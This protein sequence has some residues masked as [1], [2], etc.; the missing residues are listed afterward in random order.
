MY[1]N[2]RLEIVL[3]ISLLIMFFFSISSINE[4][5]SEKRLYN[6]LN[7]YL[8]SDINNVLLKEK[9][10]YNNKLYILYSGEDE[11]SEIIGYIEFEKNF[12]GWWCFNKTQSTREN[13]LKAPVQ[14]VL[15]NTAL[16]IC[17]KN[18]SDKPY[19]L[20]IETPDKTFEKNIRKNI[21]YLYI[22]E[23]PYN[24]SKIKISYK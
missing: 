8:A 14:S 2:K 20:L 18:T 5:I 23:I 1:R 13:Y 22:E 24:S 3:I 11:I 7:Y 12:I 17:G 21:Y 15:E 6:N 10:T 9:L 19:K 4:K 16:L